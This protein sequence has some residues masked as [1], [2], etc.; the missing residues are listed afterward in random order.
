MD[1]AAIAST[2]SFVERT[3]QLLE[4]IDYRRADT[5]EE[6]DA[7]C[8]QR[9]DAY[10]RENTITPNFSRRITDKYD[11]SSWM[12]GLFIDNKLSSSLRVSVATK[13]KPELPALQVFAEYV[14]PMLQAGKTVV[15]PTRFVADLESTRMYPQIA[16]LTARLGWVAGEYF[17][18]DIILSCCRAEHRAFYTRVWGFRPVCEPRSY[19]TLTKG[20]SLMMIDYPAVRDWVHR[21]YPFFRS[22]AF[23]RRMLFERGDAVAQRTATAA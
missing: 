19:P 2:P 18:A 17:N 14:T 6:R 22:T 1:A 3:T 21:R 13:Q 9:Y 16:W 5:P 12:F 8:R 10:L 15:D 11:D 4:R 23:E 20:I 7:I